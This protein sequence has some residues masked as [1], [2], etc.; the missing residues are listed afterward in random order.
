[1]QVQLPSGNA[2]F[3]FKVY[4]NPLLSTLLTINRVLGGHGGLAADI[5][6]SVRLANKLWKANLPKRL[7][8]SMTEGRLMPPPEVSNQKSS[9]SILD[10]L[11]PAA[12]SL[13]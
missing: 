7:V 4:D 6:A 9:H 1:L 10:L 3:E 2:D 5:L 13:A 8:W 11:N 12:A